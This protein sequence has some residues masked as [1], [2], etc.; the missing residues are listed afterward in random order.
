MIQRIVSTAICILLLVGS[1]GFAD[2]VAVLNAGFEEAGDKGLPLSWTGATDVYQRD[3]AVAHSGGA[4]LRFVNT[5]PDH[6]VLCSQRIDLEPGRMYESS[7]WVKTEGVEGKDSG[8]TICLEWSDADGKYL[9]GS[10]PGGVKGDSDWTLVR[11]LSSRVPENA[12]SCSVTCYVRKGMTGTAWWDDV[13]VARARE[14]PLRTVLLEPNYRGE[15]AD[16]GPKKARIRAVVDLRDYDLDLED[17]SL[18]WQIL[19]A[20]DEDVV[21]RGRNKRLRKETLALALPVSKLA[22]GDYEVEVA[23]VARASGE[24]LSTKRHRLGRI[25]T[26]PERTAYIDEHNRLILGGEPF[27][28]LGMYWGGIKDDELDI[29]ADSAFNCL[30]PYG[31]PTQEQMDWAHECGLKVIYSIKDYY[32]DTKYCPDEIQSEADEL[33]RVTEKV[34]AFHDH[35][36]LMAWYINDELPL[37]MLDRLSAR[38]RLIETLD[39]N[40]PTWVVLYQID[41]VG[42]YLPTFDVIGTDPYPIPTHPPSRAANWTRKTVDAVQ[43]ARA[44]WQ[45]PQVFNWACYRK[46][47]EDKANC[48]PP[49]Y[50]EMR[51]M[52]WQCIAEDANG[53][54]CYSWF[55]IRRDTARPFDD[56]WPLL[57][58]VAQ[59]VADLIPALLSV[60]KVPRIEVEEAPWLNWTAR[61]LDKTTYLIV[62]NNSREPQTAEFRFRRTPKSVMLHGQDE[63]IASVSGRRLNVELEPLGVRIYELDRLTWRPFR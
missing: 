20:R 50:E 52:I 36:A 61:Q 8:A 47:E 18:T 38:Q 21:A 58:A 53:I 44:V 63:P 3:D 59:E 55:D 26:R 11:G 62:V 32:Y 31:R 12:V 24:V 17:V 41:Q 1:A 35:P 48:R 39:P 34:D 2:D 60:E 4:S 14:D 15:I 37:S 56:H 16:D 27:F 42:K 30:M 49:T 57:K 13:S 9:G 40:H 29:Y 10:Y 45:V 43:G 5:D 6:Y 25:K 33:T 23:L 7:V 46:T 51:S 19:D 22:P 54:I 28:P